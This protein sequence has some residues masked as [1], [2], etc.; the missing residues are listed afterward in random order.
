MIKKKEKTML[1]F[2]ESIPD[3]YTAECLQVYSALCK[4]LI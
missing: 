4:S 3:D 1:G 2:G